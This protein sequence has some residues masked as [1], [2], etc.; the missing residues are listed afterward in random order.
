MWSRIVKAVVLFS[1]IT[2]LCLLGMLADRGAKAQSKRDQAELEGLKH[3][4]YTTGFCDGMKATLKHAPLK[5][6]SVDIAPILAEMMSSDR[7]QP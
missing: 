7:G 1:V 3:R 5:T 2:T 4:W 6:N